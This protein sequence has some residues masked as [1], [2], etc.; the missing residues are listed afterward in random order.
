M[1]NNEHA[2]HP[3]GNELFDI[4]DAH[5]RARASLKWATV[6]SDV[7]PAWVAEMDVRLAPAISESLQNALFRD[8][9]GY[10]GSSDGVSAAFISFASDRW[11]WEIDPEQISIHI[12]AATA[13]SKLMHYYAGTD[14]HVMLMPPVYNRFYDWMRASQV[15]PYEVP[16]LDVANGG[17]LDFTRIEEGLAAGVGVILL[18]HP[19]NPLGRVY[20]QQELSQLADLA[21]QYDAVVISDEI[22][23]PMVY[24][25]VEFVPWLAVSETAQ[26]TGIALHTATKSWNFAGLKCGIAVRSATGPWPPE[27]DPQ[28]ALTDTGFWG[29]LATEAAFR[30]SRDWLDAVRAHFQTQTKLLESLL[31]QHLPGVSFHP[32][33]ASFLAWLDFRDTSLSEEP[34]DYFL[35]EARVALSPGLSFGPVGAGCARLNL[36]TSA[37]R[38]ERIVQAMGTAWPAR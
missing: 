25:G 3:A 19:Q 36:G 11:D 1:I 9:A 18:C 20:S 32:P 38:L 7:L 33:Q 16:L 29:I 22:H 35:R 4:P 28:L 6:D 31:A 27:F 26:R 17:F 8:D 12:D 5:L 15:R 13:A 10:P 24:H 34:A 2:A 30:D 21:D 23:A 37:E 14:G